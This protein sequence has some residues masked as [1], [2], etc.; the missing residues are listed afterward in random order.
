MLFIIIIV[1]GMAPLFFVFIIRL[2]VPLIHLSLFSL[3]VIPLKMNVLLT[4]P[5]NFEREIDT[6]M[7]LNKA[8]H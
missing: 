2:F 8:A 6:G 1:N 3:T 7:T 5:V 4:R